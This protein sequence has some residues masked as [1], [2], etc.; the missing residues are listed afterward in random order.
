MAGENEY[1]NVIK[2]MKNGKCVLKITFYN[3]KNQPKDNLAC[4]LS[5][6]I[7]YFV[8]GGGTYF[9]D[10]KVYEIYPGA[11]FFIPGGKNHFIK[12]VNEKV[13]FVNIWFDPAEFAY[14]EDQ[15]SVCRRLFMR[16]KITK[17]RFDPGTDQYDEIKTTVL[18]LYKEASEK[19]ENHVWMIE[20][21]IGRLIVLLSRVYNIKNDDG[22]GLEDNK[23]FAFEQSVIFI[24]DRITR[25]FTLQELADIASVSR[26]YYCRVFKTNIGVTVRQYINMRRIDIAKERLKNTNDKIIDIA[27]ACGFN[28][29]ANF[30]KT[31]KKC[32]GTTPSEYR[33]CNKQSNIQKESQK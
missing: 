20:M 17:C 31:F 25:D 7:A 27:I 5:Q 28:T 26:N 21:M 29:I 18:Q 13:D 11:I 12:E 14:N 4:H 23:L 30:N 9:I 22:G 2:Q 19:K 16:T 32:A 15:L 24:N 33:A 6:E 10:G 8:S 1:G 3:V